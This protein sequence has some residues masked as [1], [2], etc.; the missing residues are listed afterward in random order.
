MTGFE[1]QTFG[2]ASDRTT[3]WA[4]TS[5][6]SNLTYVDYKWVSGLKQ[7]DIF[8]LFQKEVKSLK[9]KYEK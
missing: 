3:N 8:L 5:A 4:T 1:P 7:E 9:A 2:I 6:L